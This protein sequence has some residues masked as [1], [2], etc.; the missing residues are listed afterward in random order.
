MAN[1]TKNTNW[2][3]TYTVDAAGDKTVS[4]DTDKKYV[5]RDIAVKVSVPAGGVTASGTKGSGNV[6]GT[7]CVLSTSDTSGVSVVG[8]GTVTPK[9]TITAGYVGAETKTAT[10]VTSN[11]QTKY[12]TEVTIGNSKSFKITDPINSWT[13]TVDSSGNVSIV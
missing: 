12:I 9:A 11:T 5:D 1:A 3:L 4:L 13:W 7:N 8:K 2:D 6:T 10:A